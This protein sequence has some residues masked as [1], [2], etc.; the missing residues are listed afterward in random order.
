M[1]QQAR[2]NTTAFIVIPPK[3]LLTAE[4]QQTNGESSGLAGISATPIELRWPCFSDWA[5]SSQADCSGNGDRRRRIVTLIAID[6]TPTSATTVKNFV[7]GKSFL[8]S[9]ESDLLPA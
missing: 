7:F 1:Q 4:G 3:R 9:L 2:L 5:S 8:D 6:S